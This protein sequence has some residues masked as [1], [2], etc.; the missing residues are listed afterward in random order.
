MTA[1]VNFVND[2]AFQNTKR[3]AF[4]ENRLHTPDINETNLSEQ[5]KRGIL[6]GCTVGVISIHETITFF[7]PFDRP[8]FFVLTKFAVPEASTVG[9]APQNT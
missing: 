4:K 5:R 1:R 3:L 6:V 8:V 7:A 9:L 2:L